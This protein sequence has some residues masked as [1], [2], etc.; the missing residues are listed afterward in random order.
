MHHRTE[1]EIMKNWKTYNKPLVSICCV[2]YN[3]EKYVEKALDSFLMQ[4]TDFSFEIVIDDD[5]STDNTVELIKEYI[6]KYPTLMNVRL[7]E[8]NVG[9]ISNI[10]ENIQ[11]SNG[12]YIA[13]C[14]GDDYWTDPVKLQI[15]LDLMMENPECYL[16]FHPVNEVINNELSGRVFADHGAENR[17]FTDIEMV[18]GISGPFCHTTSMVFRRKAMDPTPDFFSIVPVCDVFIQLLASLNGGAL[19]IG[20]KMSAYRRGHP[21]SWSI[22]M[23]EKDRISVDSHIKNREKHMMEYIRSLDDLGNYIDQKYRI[24]I[25]KK[26]SKRLVT[27]SILYLKYNRYKMFQEMIVQSH[28]TYKIASLPHAFVYYFRFAPHLLKTMIQLSKRISA[29]H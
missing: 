19:F 17:I 29:N 3:H 18:R 28:K 27:L 7:R 10:T 9:M 20:R 23:H 4:N 15:Q 6:K 1:Q 14:E 21:G 26:I 16:S 8:E 24:E 11:R 25:N 12:D 2:T 22:T 13:L 5:C